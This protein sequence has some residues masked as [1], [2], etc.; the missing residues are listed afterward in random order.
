[1][2][3]DVS[4]KHLEDL[5]VPD[6]FDWRLKIEMQNNYEYALDYLYIKKGLLKWKIN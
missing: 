3:Y 5:S 4:L 2:R 1:M 6:L